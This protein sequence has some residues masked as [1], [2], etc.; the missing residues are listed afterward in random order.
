MLSA[1]LAF[2]SAV[3]AR[4]EAGL[5]GPNAVIQLAEALRAAPDAPGLAEHVFG[6]AGYARLLRS[7]PTDMIDE[8]IAARLF[9]TLWR[10][11]PAASA[12]AIAH[13]AG[14]R[15]GAYVLAHRIP[16]L[17]R[18]LLRTLPPRLAAP[19]LLRAIAR[20]AWTFAGSGRCRT[21]S[22]PPCL[23]TIARNPLAM[24]GGAWHG[25]V[26]ECLFRSL[27]SRSASV[28]HAEVSGDGGPVCRFEIDIAPPAAPAG[29]PSEP[30]R[31]L[32]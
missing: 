31:D 5:V 4:G 8:A 6:R 9:A 23:V 27:V 24:P 21:A 19:L 13:E 17:A 2:A 26:F 32:A 16:P 22:G 25:G 15:T 10:E 14:R 20:H 18:L 30:L 28:R 29:M 12:A 3:D 7:P 11:M 1:G